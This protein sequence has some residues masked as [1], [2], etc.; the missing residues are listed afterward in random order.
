MTLTDWEK[1]DREALRAVYSAGQVWSWD[2]IQSGATNQGR[3]VNEW[4][5][6]CLPPGS[7][8][9]LLPVHRM[10][11]TEPSWLAIAFTETQCE[12]LREHLL[13]FVGAAGSDFNGQRTILDPTDSLDSAARHWA[14]GA[15]VFRFRALGESRVQVRTALERMRNVWRIRPR[16]TTSSF[17]TT[18]AMLR[19]FHQ[20]LL[21]LDEAS[22]SR[23]LE[24]LRSGG[25]LNAENLLFLK[26]ESL[27]AFDR[28]QN[29]V[30]DPQWPMLLLMR[31]P[32]RTTALLIE[33]LWRTEF[34]TMAAEGRATDAIARMRESILPA[35]RQLFRTRG[36]F[37][38]R[39][40]VLAFLLA[41]AADEPPRSAQVAALL[42]DIPEDAPE[43]DFA[44]T[45]AGTITVQR[46]PL[47]VTDPLSQA[48]QCLAHEDY[49]G[50]WA[51][52]KIA[53]PSPA[54]CAV[55]LRC[56]AE[57]L[58]GDV[59]RIVSAALAQCNDS[60]RETLLLSRLH[61]HTWDDIQAEL[62]KSE[63]PTPVDW[64]SWLDALKANTSWPGA[65]DAAIS[66]ASDWS[67]DAYRRDPSR[68][69]ALADRLLVERTAEGSDVLRLAFP[70]LARF[71]TGDIPVDPV[72]CPVLLNLL[73]ML[74]LDTRFGREDWAV[75]ENLALSLLDAG[76]SAS[77]YTEVVQALTMIWEQR[78]EVSRLDWA[79]DLLDKLAT[80]PNLDG[81]ARDRFFEVIRKT[82]Y[83]HRRR[84]DATQLEF[85]ALL[86]DDLH[87][88]DDFESLPSLHISA[89]IDEV[90]LPTNL[91]DL[92]RDKI[93]GIYTLT[94]V[95]GVRAKR[96]L[97]HMIPKID[98]RLSHDHGGSVRLRTI[99]READY[100]VVVT[101]S[102]KHAAT[103]F[104]KSERPKGKRDLI[105][106]SGKGSS[107]LIS[108]LF[109][110][111]KQEAL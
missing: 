47:P 29:I 18:D 92:L 78:G 9:I 58:N 59:A 5:A 83:D 57:L 86:C 80:T 16:Q 55:M 93:V 105:Y 101:Q 14:G 20:A 32:R 62:A 108:A 45:I 21:T 60:E 51:Y 13:A 1:E 94:E 97:E 40:L 75:A 41:S 33:A 68:T 23:W 7:N 111:V 99:A 96:L 6:N 50:A 12:E 35:H 63:Q 34:Q 98:V 4:I 30:L 53:L 54:T 110:Y 64:E 31:R 43:R 67:I 106:P 87:R 85:F 79:L 15:R 74:A 84:I 107:S 90:T 104:I 22:S 95:A 103:D 38:S 8:P 39:P 25:R 76:A 11:D 72:F 2:E 71:F 70:H 49:D 17:R 89:S 46:I 82:F 24:Q 73:L 36:S 109:D 3:K 61:R 91:L 100:L 48:K 42:A 77:D 66:S 102:S 10:G 28:W 65:L 27:A 81:L 88:R 56:A 52:A 37:N 19:E 26:I 69:T 44:V